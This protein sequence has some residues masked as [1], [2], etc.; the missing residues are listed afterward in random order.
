MRGC[1][2][3]LGPLWRG[4]CR[5]VGR[6]WTVSGDAEQEPGPLSVVDGAEDAVLDG[7]HVPVA[8]SCDAVQVPVLL[9]WRVVDVRLVL[10]LAAVVKEAG[11]DGAEPLPAVEAVVRE[12]LAGPVARDE[13][14]RPV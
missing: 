3:G 8:R 4:R 5:N 2:L 6:L 9:H 13:E 1:L 12:G 7:V 11:R 14:R 10:V